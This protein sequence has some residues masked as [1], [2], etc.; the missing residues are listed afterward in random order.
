MSKP[1]TNIYTDYLDQNLTTIEITTGKIL[2][3]IWIDYDQKEIAQQFQWHL[4]QSAKDCI[5]AKATD[6]INK[7]KVTLHRLLMN[8][9]DPKIHIDHINRNT[10]DNRQE[11][12][13]LS[14]HTK[15][16]RNR[17]FS[18]KNSSGRTGVRYDEIQ[19]RFVAQFR[20]QS[21]NKQFKRSFAVDRFGYDEAF[22]L[23]CQ[24]REQW[25]KQY[26]VETERTKE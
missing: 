26:G 12:L 20:I 24:A 8:I 3:T 16:S 18:E 2:G 19:N 9:D 4:E 21:C 5:Y 22:K 17:R 1:K 6:N 10:F 15:N 25:E 7:K 11:N 13:R 23:A 14:D